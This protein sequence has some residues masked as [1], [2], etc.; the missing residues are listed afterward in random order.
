VKADRS[1]TPTE[2]AR[3]RCGWRSA[4]E[5]NSSHKVLLTERCAD[6]ASAVWTDART[7]RLRCAQHGF[8]TTRWSRCDDWAAKPADRT[9]EQR[10]A[11]RAAE[12]RSI[13]KSLA[14]GSLSDSDRC[15]LTA[16]VVDLER[17][18]SHGD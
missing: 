7:P 4:T 9:A 18:A 11:D 6:C 8:A 5:T 17:E 12:A 2:Q 13:R 15:A 16:R 10:A 1:G 14:D 3:A